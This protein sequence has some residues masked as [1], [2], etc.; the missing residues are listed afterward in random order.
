MAAFWIFIFI[1]A[2]AVA[3]LI[4]PNTY[5]GMNWLF[6]FLPYTHQHRGPAVSNQ[7]GRLFFA[8]RLGG[9]VLTEFAD[10]D[11][12]IRGIIFGWKRNRP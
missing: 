3:I 11:I 4:W 5:M 8:P 9:A 2:F 10:A 1:I 7:P 6:Y 12:I